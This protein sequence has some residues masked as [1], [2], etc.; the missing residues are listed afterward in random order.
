MTDDPQAFRR[1]LSSFATGVAVVTARD[2]HGEPIGITINSFNSVSLDPPLVLWSVAKDTG[3]YDS[4][5]SAEHFA[6]N[7]LGKDQ[8]NLCDRFA[9]T[10]ESSL[11]VQVFTEGTH[12]VPVLAEYAACFECRTEHLYD[13]GDHTIIVG[14]VLAFEDHETDPLIFYRG[15]F[16]S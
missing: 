6:V 15:R 1:A 11:E 5:V 8:K 2:A 4:F 16:R 13:G 9:Q 7:V 10:G 12:G 14:R 3:N